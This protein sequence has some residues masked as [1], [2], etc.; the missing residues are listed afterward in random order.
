MKEFNIVN[1][2]KKYNFGD[3]DDSIIYYRKMK[4]GQSVFKFI[5]KG[6]KS[7]TKN[8]VGSS[9]YKSQII[10]LE[11]PSSEITGGH[12]IPWFICGMEDDYRILGFISKNLNSK[13][14]YIEEQLKDLINN[15]NVYYYCEMIVKDDMLIITQSLFDEEENLL[16]QGIFKEQGYVYSKNILEYSVVKNNLILIEEKMQSLA[17]LIKEQQKLNE[18][19]EFLKE[20]I[21]IG[22][23]KQLEICSN[24]K[25]KTKLKNC[26]LGYPWKGT[27]KNTIVNFY[28]QNGS[29]SAVTIAEKSHLLNQ[30]KDKQDFNVFLRNL[31]PNLATEIRKEFGKNI[32]KNAL[33]NKHC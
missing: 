32:Y 10:P 28:K 1:N 20:S 27:L 2:R 9:K 30:I 5:S 22:N 29:T 7:C 16:F 14:C 4:N 15:Q 18:D 23:A 13:M 33:Q 3:K 25:N 24:I 8:R 31:S 6:A 12:L 17:K 11:L 26:I 19:I 21:S